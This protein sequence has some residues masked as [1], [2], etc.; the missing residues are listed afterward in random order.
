VSDSDNQGSRLVSLVPSQQL[1]QSKKQ[2]L[3]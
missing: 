1:L 3:E 2:T